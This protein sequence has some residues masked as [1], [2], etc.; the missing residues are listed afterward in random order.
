MHRILKYILFLIIGL[1]FIIMLI[2]ASTQ[3]RL[4]KNWLRDFAINK[5]NELID[6]KIQVKRV[7]G[8]LF[9]H[10]DLSGVLLR[11]EQDTVLYLPKISVRYSPLSLLHNEIYI[12]NIIIESPQ[13]NLYQLADSSWNITHILKSDST[14]LP[15]TTKSSSPFNLK[16]TLIDFYLKNSQIKIS[17]FDSSIPKQIKNFTTR[18]SG[19]YSS[20]LQKIQLEEFRFQSE[21][22]DLNLKN[23]SFVAYRDTTEISLQ[24]FVLK[25]AQN[26]VDV[27]GK[28]FISDTSLLKMELK[29]NPINLKEFQYILPSFKF[30]INPKLS[31]KANYRQN[32]L[33]LDLDI[34]EKNQRIS[35][36]ADVFHIDQLFKNSNNRDVNYVLKGNIQNVNVAKWL[37]NPQLEFLINSDFYLKGSGISSRTAQ[38]T[39]VG[40]F[41]DCV[42][43]Q[44]Y[45][46]KI[47]ISA[48]YFKGDLDCKLQFI[49]RESEVKLKVDVIDIINLQKFQAFVS[50]KNLNLANFIQGENL[51]SDLT[52][53]LF[54]HGNGINPNRMLSALALNLSPSSFMDIPIDT[55]FSSIRIDS[56]CFYI[57]TLV[58]KST[59]IQF[60]MSGN[61]SFEAENDLRFNARLGDLMA[62]N[63]VIKADTI[64]ATGTIWGNLTGMIDSLFADVE[65][66]FN[67]VIFDSNKADSLAGHVSAS[68]DSAG[69]TGKGKIFVNKI[70]ISGLAIDQLNL[71]TELSEKC[72]EVFADMLK[73]DLLD[74]KLNTQIFPDST[75]RIVI[76][77]IGLNIKDRQWTGGNDNMQVVFGN[78]T[79]Q[80]NDFRL[81]APPDSLVEERVFSISGDFSLNDQENLEVEISAFDIGILSSIIG[82][83]TELDGDLYLHLNMEGTAER[84]IISGHSSIMN[85][86][87]YD[88]TYDKMAGDFH[89][90]NERLIWNFSLNITET[91]SLTVNGFLPINLSLC[92]K[93]RFLVN[94]KEMEV[95]IKSSK[96]PLGLPLADINRLKDVK[97]NIFVD[98]NIQNTIKDPRPNGFI[99]IQDGAF[100]IPE[101]GIDYNDLQMEIV[102]ESTH[103]KITKLE[104][105]RGTGLLSAK[106]FIDL[107]SS[108]VSGKFSAAELQLVADKFYVIQHK[109]YEI[110]LSA[111]TQLGGDPN[112]PKFGGKVEIHRSSFYLP[113]LMEGDDRDEIKEDKSIPILIEATQSLDVQS[114]SSAHDFKIKSSKKDD[115]FSKFLKKLEGTMKISIPRNTWIKSPNM[116]I[117]IS[118]NIDLVK[119]GSDFELFGAIK[120]ERGYYNLFGRKFD[121]KE[122]SLTFRGGREFN[123]HVILETDY[124][125]RTSAREKK[126]LKL[127]VGGE[128]LKPSFQFKLDGK[129]ISE[130]DAVSYLVFGQSVDELTYGQQSEIS[131]SSG[132]QVNILNIA[133]SLISTELAK[134]VGR[135]LNLDYL[136]IKGKSNWQRATFVVGKYITDDL[137]VSYQREFGDSDEEDI[138]PETITVEYEVT[139]NIF[140]QLIEG[141]SKAKGFDIII[142]FER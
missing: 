78:N 103:L 107:D 90:D 3:T 63:Y 6:G 56:N 75:L 97:G 81:T 9:K 136:E 123:P 94:N 69:I 121:I 51:Q 33:R 140:L 122:G 57:D 89:Y 83:P 25:T 71:E 39:F 14:S 43:F 60:E 54:A 61:A 98:L 30:K 62:V 119:N 26:Q 20:K 104:A 8:N 114:D 2:I 129:D 96:I 118:G 55:L 79:F 130:T 4:F 95:T 112:N 35:L 48:D 7:G 72:I 16:I 64:N 38:V 77:M 133:T 137:F 92:P 73:Q 80:I 17:T 65:F 70:G 139:Q 128:F 34:N 116:R 13:I 47:D 27:G 141:N 24:N 66:Q 67:N 76:P 58:L 109:D 120:V 42:F 59:P 46:P 113:A 1:I 50:L 108:L 74:V 132:S 135:D 134:T 29:T 15:D 28:Y 87:V 142:K 126:T 105:K 40:N 52:L 88:Y 115:Q 22:P 53:N 45:V 82:L 41:S 131:G 99:R 36:Q 138:A 106:G 32:F 102:A 127:T 110:Q 124:S 18:F 37:D 5:V 23:L 100:K 111:N 68:I 84:P 44:E 101:L 19:T 21:Q 117:E 12:E 91:D 10:V 85:G 11:S 49:T 31:L 86:L 125:F 93:N